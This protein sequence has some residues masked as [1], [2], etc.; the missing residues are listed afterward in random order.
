MTYKSPIEGVTSCIKYLISN[1]RFNN[2]I[3]VG[4]G[5]APYKDLFNNVCYTGIDLI[6]NDGDNFIKQN[7]NQYDFKDQ[8]YDCVFTSHCI[9]HQPNIEFF[10]RKI[11]S[12]IKNNGVLCILWP[13]PKENVVGGHVNMFNPGMLLYN[14]TRIGFDCSRVRCIHSGYTYGVVGYVSIVNEVDLIYDSGDIELL[15]H[16]FPFNAK[17]AFHGV[18]DV[19]LINL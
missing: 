19:D 13:P 12:I 15:S 3:D 6:E 16:L 4:C 7:F 14:L 10:L 8:E 17:H 18:R 9:E 11:K 1:Y 5:Y 2:L